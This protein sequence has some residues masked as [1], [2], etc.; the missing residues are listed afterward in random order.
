MRFYRIVLGS[1]PLSELG[2]TLTH[3]HVSL[4]FRNFYV[5]PPSQLK[6]YL[7]NRLSLHNIGFV[8]QYP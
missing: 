1:K 4:D 8:K 7:D 5:P 2:K 6:R 3:E